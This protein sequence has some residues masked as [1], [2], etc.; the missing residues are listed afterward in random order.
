ME[1]VTGAAAEAPISGKIET[2]FL[3]IAPVFILRCLVDSIG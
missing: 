2:D 1:T 3:Y